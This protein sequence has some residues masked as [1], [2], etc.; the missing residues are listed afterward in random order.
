M[1]AG[2]YA[3]AALGQVVIGRAI[4]V[5]QSTASAFLVIAATCVVGA[6]TIVPVKK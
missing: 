4:D 2:A 6:I 5:S 1:D 3:F